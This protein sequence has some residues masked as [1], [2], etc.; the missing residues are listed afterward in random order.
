MK[1]LTKANIFLCYAGLALSIYSFYVE[2]KKENDSNYEALCDINERVSCS[3][4][5][6]SK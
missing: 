5:F 4:V 6:M 1:F 3:S 2:Y